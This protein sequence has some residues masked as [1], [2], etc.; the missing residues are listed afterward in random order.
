MDHVLYTKV[1]HLESSRVRIEI[2][3]WDE[4][5]LLRESKRGRGL[6]RRSLGHKNRG[7]EVLSGNWRGY[8]LTRGCK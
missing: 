5:R 3:L 8:S 7:V 4:V 1:L 6:E 2:I